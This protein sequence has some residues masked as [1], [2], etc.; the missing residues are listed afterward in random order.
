M[1]DSR[2]PGPPVGDG[3]DEEALHALW[4][5]K[6]AV[7]P[8]CSYETAQAAQAEAEALHARVREGT[9]GGALPRGNGGTPSWRR[10]GASRPTSAPGPGAAGPRVPERA[11][12]SSPAASSRYSVMGS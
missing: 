11:G 1:P 9:R 12:Q 6:K 4:L 8:A 5:A 7:E 2:E 3:T 10:R